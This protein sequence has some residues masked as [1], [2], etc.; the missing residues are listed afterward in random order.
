[1]AGVL[2]K[3]WYYAGDLPESKE[4]IDFEEVNLS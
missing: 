3:L 1:M 2:V 4:G